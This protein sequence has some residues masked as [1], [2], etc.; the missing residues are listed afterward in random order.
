MRTRINGACTRCLD[1][2]PL[3]T[4]ATVDSP[5]TRIGLKR[6]PAYDLFLTRTL[7]Y[8]EVVRGAEGT[9]VFLAENLEAAAGAWGQIVAEVS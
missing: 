3:A 8:A 9:G 2:S 4:V 5:G 1:R 6:G 7:R